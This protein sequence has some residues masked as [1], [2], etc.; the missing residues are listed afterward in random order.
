MKFK[1]GV[2]ICILVLLA[3]ANGQRKKCRDEDERKGKRCQVK[4]NGRGNARK[5]TKSRG[6]PA[7]PS[8]RR[9]P[10]KDSQL[11]VREGTAV[12]LN[13][14]MKGKPFPIISWLKNG[15]SLN[16]TASEKYRQR[17][18]RLKIGSIELDD[19]A[20]YTCI[21]KNKLGH[22]NFTYSI[23]VLENMP[24]RDI[25]VVDKPK[26]QTAHVGD[27]VIFLCRSEDWPK[28]QV[29][30]SR[31]TDSKRI[32]EVIQHA[33]NQ[34]DVLVLHNVTKSDTGKYTCYVSNVLVR[35]Q[36]SARLTVIEEGE[37]L[38]FEPNCSLHVRREHFL[39]KQT[40]CK[41]KEP[42]EMRYCMG[43]CGRSY[44]VPKVM[45]SDHVSL[46]IP[47]AHLNQ[48]CKC[49]VGVVSDLR[50]VQLQCPLGQTKRAFYTLLGDCK[51]QACGLSVAKNSTSAEG[52]S[53]KK[54]QN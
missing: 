45:T 22:L 28:P 40:G 23:K 36:L 47:G 34:S 17:R 5:N 29:H 16:P 14:P 27:T 50:I 20:T 13:C 37:A 43:S 15:K 49:C 31:E 52:T 12:T 18:S 38:P 11:I 44:Y 19:I 9:G 41:T 30:W 35:K 2:Q 26:N 48:P 3:L 33:S 10:P 4:R 8:W 54:D 46:S 7:A 53:V 32:M 25:D 24:L 42:L 21:G 39:D 6:E 51:C 1:A